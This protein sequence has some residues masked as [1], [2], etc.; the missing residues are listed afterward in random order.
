MKNILSNNLKFIIKNRSLLL[1]FYI[2]SFFV[3]RKYYIYFVIYQTIF[4][5]N[6]FLLKM[7]A[8]LVD[9]QVL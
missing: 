2:L 7:Q 3:L 1:G 9:E 8:F 5:I 6:L 4:E